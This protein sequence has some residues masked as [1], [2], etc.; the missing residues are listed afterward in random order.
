MR[1][2]RVTAQDVYQMEDEEYRDLMRG[3]LLRARK[4]QGRKSNVGGSVVISLIL[5]LAGAAV[6]MHNYGMIQLPK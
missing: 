4:N 6:I 5:L 2:K 3:R 1:K